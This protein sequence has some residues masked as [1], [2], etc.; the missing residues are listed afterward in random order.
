MLV[1]RTERGGDSSCMDMYIVI[2]FQGCQINKRIT[3]SESL[4]LILVD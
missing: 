3:A 2:L 4:I 1:L